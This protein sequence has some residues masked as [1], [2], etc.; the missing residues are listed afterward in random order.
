MRNH[1]EI[2]TSEMFADLQAALT[3]IFLIQIVGGDDST[4][5]KERLDGKR[6]VLDAIK[7]LMQARF[8]HAEIVEFIEK[9]YPRSVNLGNVFT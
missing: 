1:T 8:S 6:G 9:G 7:E 5:F 2:P 3:E 4:D